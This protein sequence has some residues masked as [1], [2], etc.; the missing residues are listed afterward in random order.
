MRALQHGLGGGDGLVQFATLG[1][2]EGDGGELVC[3]A[4]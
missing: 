2:D 4:A 1:Q 3:L